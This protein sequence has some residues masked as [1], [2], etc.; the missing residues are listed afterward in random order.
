MDK[1]LLLV[2]PSWLALSWHACR[3]DK[4]SR[5]LTRDSL[6]TKGCGVQLVS[7]KQSIDG[8]S[9]SGTSFSLENC[10]RQKGF[11]VAGG[12]VNDYKQDMSQWQASLADPKLC[13]VVSRQDP[14]DTEDLLSDE[15]QARLAKFRSGVRFLAHCPLH[16]PIVSLES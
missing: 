14:Q 4:T 16:D 7:L 10:K 5:Q 1:M 6:D 12:K 13:H 11:Q 15:V 8:G 3:I 9:S 2:H